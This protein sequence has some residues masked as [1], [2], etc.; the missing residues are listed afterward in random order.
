VHI[1]VLTLAGVALQAAAIS[2]IVMPSLRMVSILRSVD[3]NL[4][5][6]LPT[7]LSAS[8]AMA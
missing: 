3:G 6:A 4:A 7:I 2:F 5:M 8:W 1:I